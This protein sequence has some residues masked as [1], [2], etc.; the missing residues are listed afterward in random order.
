MPNETASWCR[1]LPQAIR[2]LYDQ[3]E[4]SPQ[5]DFGRQWR[6]AL[7]KCEYDTPRPLM[8]RELSAV[9]ETAPE[10]RKLDGVAQQQ[11]GTNSTYGK[12][13]SHSLIV[14]G[15]MSCWIACRGFRWRS[16]ASRGYAANGKT[17]C[18]I[19]CAAR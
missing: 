15:T 2:P 7:G 10:A 14:A 11:G 1:T 8:L 5:T 3:G 19:G 6:V 4:G 18:R 16:R 17:N 13:I 12:M 9:A